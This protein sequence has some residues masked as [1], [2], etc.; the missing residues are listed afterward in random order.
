MSY[1]GELLQVNHEPWDTDLEGCVILQVHFS[2]FLLVKQGLAIFLAIVCP[3]VMS[4]RDPQ[5]LR[6]TML[7]F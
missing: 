4:S 1:N 2:A 6:T 7:D 5:C 3:E